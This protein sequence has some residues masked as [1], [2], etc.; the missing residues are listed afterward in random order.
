MQNS[1]S[2]SSR[3]VLE[4]AQEQAKEFHHRLVGTEHVLL[5]LVI[6][7]DGKAGKILRTMNVTP[8]GVRE[9]IERYTDYGSAAPTSYMEFS[10]RLTLALDYAKRNSELRSSKEIETTDILQALV[11]SE[12]ILSAMILRNLDVDLENLKDEL[13]DANQ[14]TGESSQT[15]RPDAA[16]SSQSQTPILDR[17]GID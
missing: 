14:V 8:T 6:E 2:K 12:Q 11:S 5:A 3:Q 9:E 15:S 10:P 1:Y 16:G 17:F 13:D 7:A 4:I